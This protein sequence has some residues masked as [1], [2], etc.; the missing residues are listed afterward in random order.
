[1]I[2]VLDFS[3]RTRVIV[4]VASRKYSFA[5]AP[6]QAG[7]FVVPGVEG[8]EKEPYLVYLQREV[9]ELSTLSQNL[10]RGVR[11]RFWKRFQR[12]SPRH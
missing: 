9:S 6:D 8:E 7:S 5:F 1:V 4:D 10:P 11:T 12:C 3:K 2:L